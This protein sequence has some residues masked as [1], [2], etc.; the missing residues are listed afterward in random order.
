M[1]AILKK[2]DY[3]PVYFGDPDSRLKD[4]AGYTS[5]ERWYN[6]ESDN[7]TQCA[8]YLTERFNL[9]GKKVLD[10][11]CAKGFLV[12]S[13]RKLGV[14][15]FGID[16]S[17]YILLHAEEGALAY[18]QYK[19]VPYDLNTFDDDTF[20]YLFSFRFLSC[21]PDELLQNTILEFN[22]I[23]KNQFHEIDVKALEKYYNIKSIDD[24]QRYTWKNGTILKTN[25]SSKEIIIG[26]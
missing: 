9:V 24:W 23:S 8:K 3:G 11:G 1:P 20:D 21:I 7:F 14:D 6:N 22:R 10:V 25:E 12:N 4:K 17:T 2:N 19:E 16:W 26:N 15:A 18:L 5:Y 13:L